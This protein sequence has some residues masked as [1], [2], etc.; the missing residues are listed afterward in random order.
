MKVENSVANP[1][2]TTAYS[3]LGTD[4]GARRENLAQAVGHYRWTICALLFFGTT[5][6]YV[7][8][9]VLGLLAPELQTK[10]G[11]NEAQYGYI[12]TAFQGAYAIGLLLMG[13][14]I[15]VIGTRI[16]YALS[17]GIWSIS[18]AAHALARTPLGFGVARFALG[19]GEAGNFPAAI[20]T[21]AEWFPKRERALATGIFNSGT[22][23]GATIGPL[24]VLWIA[25]R[26][27]WQSAFVSTGLLSFLP[28]I[29]WVRSYRRP[30]EHPRLSAAEL[31]Y[32]QSDPSEPATQI[33]WARLLP[34]RQTWAFLLGKFMTDPI[35]WFFLFWLPKFLNTNHGLHLTA[36]GP[37]LVVIY[38]AACVGSIAGGWLA[39]RF[40]KAGWTVNRARKTTMLLCALTVVP[41]I[42]AAN[43]RNLWTAVALVSLAT[44]GH[45]GWSAN[46]FT[47][48]SDLFP[49]RAVA[50][51]VGIGGFGGAVGGML[52][53]AFTG[54][55][56]QITGSYIPMFV[57]AG[58]AYLVALLI[59]HLLSPQMEPVRLDS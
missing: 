58:S 17:I 56:L 13:R 11:W 47:F 19:L 43:V 25:S 59:I 18:A 22:N 50:S 51:V 54:W 39:A 41:I 28:I 9:Q 24:L 53:A 48:A 49:R 8:R 5:M 42:A 1:P 15:D 34:H 4:T 21:V 52:I 29:F 6:N 46:M 23:V 16:G 38:N 55:M 32:I 2:A 26:Y 40:L 10:I 35:W 20:K 27:G 7:D 57:L 44:A 3:G 14:L 30:Q 36:L 31:Q 12:V 33:P 37:P 45:Q